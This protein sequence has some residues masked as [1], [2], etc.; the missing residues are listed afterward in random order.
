[1][2]TLLV[3]GWLLLPVIVA[4]WHYGPGQE[5]VLLGQ[6]VAVLAKADQAAAAGQWDE[7]EEWYAEALKQLPVNRRADIRRVRLERAKAQML[8]KK[9]PVA[10]HDLDDLVQELTADPSADQTLQDEARSALAS[11]QYFTT[12]QMRLE[13][14]AR[15]EWEPEIEN[16]RQNYRLLA[17]QAE[18]RGDPVEAKKRAEDLEAA[19]RLERMDLADLMGLP[20]P[21]Q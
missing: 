20:L 3:T 19:I 16:A 8:A 11:A 9:L 12:W 5:Q 18:T 10:R 14:Y 17:E 1:M 13:G 21:S 2:R 7:A 4:A 15:E 6:V